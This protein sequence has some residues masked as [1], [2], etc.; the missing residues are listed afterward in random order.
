M[1]S[2]R[3]L[4]HWTCLILLC[5]DNNFVHAIYI[6][7]NDISATSSPL[8]LNKRSSHFHSKP[9]DSP[10]IESEDGK[11]SIKRKSKRESKRPE[12][13]AYDPETTSDS[14]LHSELKRT[15]SLLPR[16]SKNVEHKLETRDFG[17]YPGTNKNAPGVKPIAS[18]GFSLASNQI[19]V[20][21]N[22]GDIRS[23]PAA[24][25]DKCTGVLD[26]ESC[27]GGELGFQMKGIF[28]PTGRKLESQHVKQG[29]IGDCGKS[30]YSRNGRPANKHRNGCC[31][32]S[33]STHRLRIQPQIKISELWKIP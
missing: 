19:S 12:V 10:L 33:F 15:K 7:K 22:M 23:Q 29:N 20:R 30:R 32:Q 3:L 2:I 24:F 21:S 5:F 13:P 4:T 16:S 27:L 18:N 8:E 28:L 9:P 25:Y 17:G 11:N 31:I 6:S 26:F 14:N 1:F